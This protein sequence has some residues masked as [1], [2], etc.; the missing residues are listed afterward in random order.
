MEAEVSYNVYKR[1]FISGFTG[2]G[3]AYPSLPD[4]EKGKSVTTFGT[5][6]RYLLA[7]KLGANMGMDFAFS[8]DDFAFYIIFGTAWLR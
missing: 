7:R 6:F 8:N 1:W 2:M 5:G 4:F 3:N